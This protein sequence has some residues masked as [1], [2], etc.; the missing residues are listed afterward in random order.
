MEINLVDLLFW[1]SC[2]F[3]S[4]YAIPQTLRAIKYKKGKGLS[5]KFIVP[6]FIDKAAAYAAVMM[7]SNLQLS[8]KYGIGL[9]C[10][11]IIGY[12]KFTRKPKKDTR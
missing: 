2:I 12:Y 3:G 8:I 7:I 11:I 9:A 1:I 10:T 6:W 4:Y 5:K